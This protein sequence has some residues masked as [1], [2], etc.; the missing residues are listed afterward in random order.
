[1]TSSSTPLRLPPGPEEAIRIDV[2]AESLE[3]LV[4]LQGE[5]GDIVSITTPDDRLVYFI[6]DP[7]EIRS[8]LIQRH[9]R[10]GKGRG[11][12]RVRMLLGNGIIVSDGDV[13]RRARTMI[14]PAFSRQNMH[15][16]IAQMILCC[17]N[18]AE[19]WED[20]AAAGGVVNITREM[21]EF[22]LELIL[23]AI[24]GSDF[25]TK[26]LQDD[27]NPFSFL[28]QDS[29]RDLSV[30]IKMR[31]LRSLL[32]EIVNSRRGADAN[33]QYDLLSTYVNA[34][35]KAG[36]Y[37]TDRELIDELITLIVAGYETS[38]STLNW[39][40]LMLATHPEAE[41]KLLQEARASMP[42]EHSVNSESIADMEYA[43]QI[44]DET[45]RLYPPVWIFSR[46]SLRDDTLTEFDVPAN[47]E[48]FFS[49]Y[50]LHR[51]E[52]HWAEPDTFDP[53]RFG[54]DAIYKK[55]NRPYYPFSLGP[56]RC[57]G[58]YFAFMEMKIHLGYL[59][60]RFH[61]D[62]ESD[63]FPGLD[64]GINLRAQNDIILRP[65]VQQFAA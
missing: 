5:F 58:E 47:T 53:S 24:F 30:V 44:L 42:D 4:R 15:K 29:T 45:L 64:L 43:Q 23:R 20:V 50:I 27:T 36:V 40:W 48:I 21:N 65:T 62:T 38:A 32:L 17:R 51:S 12:E 19:R 8:L 16:L 22:S 10:Y 52:K 54:P 7:N 28:S 2:D 63:L 60:Q 34:T 37:F 39:A 46:Q 57:L 59:V 55:G 3:T 11:F 13:W 31:N 6:N 9:S 49:P 25:E 41:Q 33:Q 18:R 35:D 61:F 14:Q 1:M 56:R 26:I